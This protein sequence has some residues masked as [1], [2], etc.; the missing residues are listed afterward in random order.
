MSNRGRLMLLFAVALATLGLQGSSSQ[1]HLQHFSVF[2]N[3]A[4]TG[5]PGLTFSIAADQSSHG[6]AVIAGPGREVILVDC[7][8][9]DDLPGLL[10]HHVYGSGV[11]AENGNRWHFR[12]EGGPLGA[13]WIAGTEADPSRPCGAPDASEWGFGRFIVGA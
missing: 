8:E 12:I 10:R 7:L 9:F 11:N 3:G 13:Q 4:K 5:D 1:A 6:V 2:G